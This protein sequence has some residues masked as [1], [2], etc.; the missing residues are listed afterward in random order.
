MSVNADRKGFV[1][2]QSVLVNQSVAVKKAM[3]IGKR[4]PSITGSL[5]D[6]YFVFFNLEGGC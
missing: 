4:P 6:L 3:K 5:S 1:M 2:K